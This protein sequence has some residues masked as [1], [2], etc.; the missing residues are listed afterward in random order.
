[1]LQL[2]KQ[3]DRKSELQAFLA[4]HGIS[5]KRLAEEIGV[6]PSMIS[7]IINGERAP[8]QRIRQ[9]LQLGIPEE[10][11]PQPSGPPGRPRRAV[12]IPETERN[13]P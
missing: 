6:S 11:L 13:S 7:R 3:R 1:M 4:Y 12:D 2:K 5:K 10:L 8:A 9:L